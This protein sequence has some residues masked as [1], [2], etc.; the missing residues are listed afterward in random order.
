MQYVCEHSNWLL[1]ASGKACLSLSELKN[2]SGHRKRIS[3]FGLFMK[4]I[5]IF[6]L[7]CR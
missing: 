7:F 4:K 1:P 6:K 5:H 2:M 3:I